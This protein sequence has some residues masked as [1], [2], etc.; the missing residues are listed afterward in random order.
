MVYKLI[1][2]HNVNLLPLELSK[3]K[4]TNINNAYITNRLIQR[5]C[6][7]YKKPKDLCHTYRLEKMEIIYL[8]GFR[9]SLPIIR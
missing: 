1:Q 8:R 4:K 2:G 7:S 5:G 6:D 9:Q 3:K